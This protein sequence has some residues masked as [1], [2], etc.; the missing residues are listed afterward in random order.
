MAKLNINRG[1]SYTRTVNFSV[2]GVPTSLIGATV[3][4]TIKTVQYDA[5]ATDA[6]AV[7]EKNIT[8]GTADGQAI[9]SLTPADTATLTPGKFYYDT[10]VDLNSDAVT[11]YPI[12]TGTIVLVGSPTN[13]LS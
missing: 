12:D 9:I 13:R 8:N 10:K 3:R 11:V 7:V 6:S 5:D 1:T 2:D 4:F